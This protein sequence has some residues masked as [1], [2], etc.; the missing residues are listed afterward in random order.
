MPIAPS[1]GTITAFFA[2]SKLAGD[3]S[4][5]SILVARCIVVA[6]VIRF[7]AQVL[8]RIPFIRSKSDALATLLIGVVWKRKEN[9]LRATRV[10]L[11][12]IRQRMR[13]EIFSYTIPSGALVAKKEDCA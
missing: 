5:L 13:A 9:E 7:E 6:T 4:A 12:V 10:T 8:A 1:C 11:G 2:L 3:P